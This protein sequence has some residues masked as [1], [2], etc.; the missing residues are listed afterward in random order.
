MHRHLSRSFAATGATALLAT[1]LLTAPGAQS[2]AATTC[3]G[4]TVTID[5]TGQPT[6]TGT[7]GNDVIVVSQGS[8]VTA[9]AGDD[10]IC[11][12]PG[13]ATPAPTP[14]A[15]TTIDAGDGND[16]VESG[17][18][19][20]PN[21]D[22]ITLGA[23]DDTLIFHG[24][25]TPA[26]SADFGEGNNTLVDSDGG[27]VAINATT[28]VLDRNGVV[29]LRWQGNVTTYVVESTAT[30]VAFTGTSANETFVLRDP[31]TGATPTTVAVDMAGGDDTIT[32]RSNVLDGSTWNGGDGTDLFQVAFDYTAL[33]LDL[34]SG[35]F[36]TGAADV[37]ADQRVS[38]FENVDAVTATVTVKGSDPANVINLQ[39]CTMTAA[40]RAGA[41]T[42]NS[43][44]DIADAPTLTCTG[45]KMVARG[46]KDAD[47][48]NGT[49]GGDRLFGNKGED[50]ISAEGGDDVIFG[51][52]D[53]DRIQGN[54]GDD[55]VRG[56]KGD[57]ELAG[58]FGKDRVQGDQDDD[59]LLAHA[60]NDVLVGGL[61]FD[62]ANGGKGIDKCSAVERS[63]KCE[64]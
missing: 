46:G 35:Q 52:D 16:S 42:I 37:T 2:A 26:G 59:R 9:L 5:G 6:V 11:V 47:T 64:R 27:V 40:S 63:S 28:K 20:Q 53:A 18:A 50:V 1:A 24:V 39:G 38:N 60:G 62:R 13:T 56:S 7:P 57:D 51:G 58:N 23:G 22:K 14:A 32:I 17:V 48:I 43:G 45:S 21:P 29:A 3:Q 19:G 30:S 31:A 54:G 34:R 25:Q 4:K 12:V 36:E 49:V 8:T 44:V 61:G 41:D 15:A 10:T 55:R 33:L